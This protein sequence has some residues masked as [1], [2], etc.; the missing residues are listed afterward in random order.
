MRE[1]NLADKTVLVDVGPEGGEQRTIKAD[2][3]VI[4]AGSVPDYRGIPGLEEHSLTV[5]NTAD[6]VAILQ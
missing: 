5:K 6:A 4:A 3:L 2:H 1:I